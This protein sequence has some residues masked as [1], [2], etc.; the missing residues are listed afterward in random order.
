MESVMAVWMYLLKKVIP[1]LNHPASRFILTCLTWNYIHY[2][3]M[4]LYYEVCID[5]SWRGF[6]CHLFGQRSGCYVLQMVAYE[7]Q[8]TLFVQIGAVV[9]LNWGLGAANR[10]IEKGKTQLGG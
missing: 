10:A 9:A 8:R 4:F 6:F 1:I 3:A 2:F 7:A 5:F